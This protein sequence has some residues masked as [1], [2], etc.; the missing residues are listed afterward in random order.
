MSEYEQ[1]FE[2]ILVAFVSLLVFVLHV[3][4]DLIPAEQVK[5]EVQIQTLKTR[6]NHY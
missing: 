3:W 5:Q 1:I 2:L 6:Q 4:E